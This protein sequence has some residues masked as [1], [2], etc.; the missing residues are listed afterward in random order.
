MFGSVIFQQ[1]ST[2][3]SS[4]LLQFQDSEDAV[5]YGCS[6]GCSAAARDRTCCLPFFLDVGTAAR[7]AEHQ[8]SA[9]VLWGQILLT[10][11]AMQPSC[12]LHEQPGS[13]E[14]PA[15]LG[16]MLLPLADCCS[17]CFSTAAESLLLV[18]SSCESRR[19]CLLTSP[20]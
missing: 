18:C 11:D 12:M 9:H 10:A 2:R 3:L 8:S 20:A 13:R 6:T 1:L 17:F 15:G 19:G 5:E 14:R 7:C 16:A 4:H